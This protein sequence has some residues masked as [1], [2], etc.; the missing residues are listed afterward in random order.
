[1]LPWLAAGFTLQQAARMVLTRHEALKDLESQG[2]LRS[3]FGTRSADRATLEALADSAS[4]GLSKLELVPAPFLA[5][6]DGAC[7]DGTRIAGAL[8]RL[9]EFRRREQ[10]ASGSFF[11]VS[12][13][14]AV[15]LLILAGLP[16][17][18]WMVVRFVCPRFFEAS[19]AALAQVWQLRGLPASGVL[20]MIQTGG[21]LYWPGAL[22]LG[23]LVAGFGLLAA[24]LLLQPFRRA[25]ERQARQI[26]ALALVLL[27]LRRG[28]AFPMAASSAAWN[29]GPRH[30]EHTLLS[31]LACGDPSPFLG[32]DAPLADAAELTVAGADGDAVAD[33]LERRL[34]QS[35]EEVGPRTL[36]EGYVT[37]AVFAVA[38]LAFFCVTLGIFLSVWLLVLGSLAVV[39]TGI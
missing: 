27:D 20:A 32:S 31:S 26:E 11:S 7:G 33:W 19:G 5:W 3:L 25:A 12:G 29:L 2:T 36:A 34:Q 8:A 1:M 15:T 38:S 37:H 6:A 16:V 13:Q 21:Q 10:L 39:V 4:D 23:T 9:L 17:V 30:P 28:D 24:W 35:A 22:W 14:G 18:L